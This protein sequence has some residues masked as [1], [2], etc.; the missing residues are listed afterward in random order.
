MLAARASFIEVGV[1]KWP[2]FRGKEAKPSARNCVRN[3]AK[4]AENHGV[5]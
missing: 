1:Q 4:H 2:V 3:A 5:E